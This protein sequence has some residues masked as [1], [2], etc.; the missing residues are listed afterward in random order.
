MHGIQTESSIVMLF[1]SGNM[2][3]PDA[4]RCADHP[5]KTLGH[6]NYLSYG[7]NMPERE[8]TPCRAVC[9]NDPGH[10]GIAVQQSTSV[11]LYNLKEDVNQR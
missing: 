3:V 6:L 10:N 11:G 8:L 4:G 7:R 1:A 9:S 5:I 2:A